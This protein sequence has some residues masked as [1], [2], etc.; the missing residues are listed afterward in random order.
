MKKV[1]CFYCQQDVAPKKILLW[2]FCP[3][4]KHRLT[5]NGEGFYRVCDRCGANMPI[6]ASVCVKCGKSTGSN[7]REIEP[8]ISSQYAPWLQWLINIAALFFSVMIAVGVIYVSFYLIFVF[9]A[10]GL[11]YFI[12]QLFRSHTK[13]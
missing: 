6:N 3:H 1:Y 2:H 7:T 9:L 13:F 4:C 12:F 10:L 11:A 8:F 5:D